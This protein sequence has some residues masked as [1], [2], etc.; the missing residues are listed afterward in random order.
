VE[1]TRH[2]Q[3]S[4]QLDIDQETGGNGLGR[5]EGEKFLI[6]QFPS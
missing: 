3:A 1:L 6:R 2:L 4:F 5:Y